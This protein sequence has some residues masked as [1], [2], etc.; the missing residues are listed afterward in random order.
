MT[1]PLRRTIC[2]FLACALLCV[3][4]PR[5]FAQQQTFR[6]YGTSDGLSNLNIRCLLQDST[7][8]LWVGTDNGL[9]RF[10]GASFR[11]FS[12]R[13]GLPSSEIHAI[14]QS[15][16]DGV[17]WVATPGGLARLDGNTFRAVPAA[18]TGGADTI[19]AIAFAPAGDMYVENA[20]GI[21]KRTSDY[22][23]GWLY[24]PVAVGAVHGLLVRND[25][26]IFGRDNDLW[27]IRG[28]RVEPIGSVHG[29]PHDAWSAFIRDQNDNFW[30]RSNTQLWELPHGATYFINRSAAIR[31]TADAQLAADQHG[32]V[33]VNTLD[34]AIDIDNQRELPL[35]SRH[36]L[37]GDSVGPMLVDRDDNLWLGLTGG[38]LVRRL[39]HGEWTS[40]KRSDGLPHNSVWSI[41]RDREK[42]VWVGT[43]AGLAL[44]DSS[45]IVRR[46]WNVHTG[47]PA[48]RVLS[49]VGIP[50]GD[51]FA[52]SDPGG[53]TQF[54]LSGHL[55]R[56]YGEADGLFR[57]ITGMAIDHQ[58]RLWA[59]GDGGCF[60]STEPARAGARLRFESIPI[61]GVAPDAV[62]RDIVM[63]PTGAVWIG[64]S[65]GILL[66]DGTQW[67]V[68]TKATGLKDSD[69]D[70]IVERDGELW[71]A[72]RDAIGMSRMHVQGDRLVGV[73]ITTRDGLSSDNLYAL[74]FDSEGRLWANSDKGVD[75]LEHGRW[76]SFGSEDGLVWDDTNGRALFIDSDDDIWIGTSA[77]LS[78][79]TRRAYTLQAAP[80]AI[81]LT[82]VHGGG[83]ERWQSGQQPVIP[84]NER[85]LSFHFRALNFTS[86]QQAYRYRVIGY[87]DH[88]IETNTRNVQLAALPA[89]HYEFQVSAQTADGTWIAQPAHF[90]FTIE[91][92]WWQRWPLLTAMVLL[93]AALARLLWFLRLRSLIAQKERLQRQVEEQTAALRDSHRQL[94]SIAYFDLLTSLPNRRMF[95]DEFSKRINAARRNNEIFALLLIDLDLFKQINDTHGHD[96]GDAVL[97]ETALRLQSAVRNC[98]CVA[99]LGGDEFAI[100]LAGS[101][102]KL[103]G[104]RGIDAVEIVC[105]RI[106][107]NCNGTIEFGANSLHIGCSIGIAMFPGDSDTEETLYKAADLALYHSKRT[108]R[109]G[110]S[111]YSSLKSATVQAATLRAPSPQRNPDSDSHPG[112]AL[113]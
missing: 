56:S 76:K 43:R 63:T 66:F 7:G 97:V 19:N 4:A 18:I 108:R 15:P 47:L 69:I 14:A 99:R 109:N 103:S 61:P 34:G 65:R 85:T 104:Q 46:T 105:R 107:N 5:L 1:I 25:S 81:V 17:L 78:R 38:G 16:T 98:D 42:N 87:Q 2:R 40:W 111:W 96:A 51:I 67:H 53:I 24:E 100:L 75:V 62:F 89:G 39:G 10:D 13:E 21:L 93:A 31:E 33:F 60:R 58:H 50:D 106:L 12:H 64:T 88:W 45:G 29:L 74:A 57:R 6:T 79:Y 54:S 3:G 101:R 22:A 90:I 112:P 32:H 20:Y 27:R 8:F 80:L 68:F 11:E 28:Q 102:D 23:G 44:M 110:F 36:G 48:D 55:L 70:S 73:N 35:D 84:Y 95:G 77:G 59:V 72:Y 71:I 83:N 113:A 37:V 94:E 91:A 26:V 30:V 9:F 41:F 86:S 49:I 92:P 82:S 52:G